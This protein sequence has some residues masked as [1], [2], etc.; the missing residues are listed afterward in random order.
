MNSAGPNIL[1]ITSDQQHWT[2]LGC[3]NPEVP[4]PHL[5]RL[6]AQGR[7]FT[8]AYCPNPT[9]TP[10][11]ASLI[12]GQ[13]PSVHGAW[14]LGTK[15]RETVPTL[16]D[17]FDDLGYDT[18]LIGKAHFQPLASTPDYPSL[19]A[20]PVLQDL[21]FWRGFHGPFY[22]FRHIEIT[23]PHTDE[24]HVGQH[25]AV[26]MEENGL[27]DW[28]RHFQPPTGTTP[29]QYG[30][31]S[32]PPEFHY[33]T[34]ITERSKARLDHCREAGQPFFLWA[35]FFDPHPPYLVPEPWASLVDPAAV[36]VPEITPGEHDRNPPHFHK[37]QEPGADFG[38]MAREPP[39]GHHGHGIH[40]HLRPRERRARDLALY[41]GMMAFTD[42]CIG[43]ILDHLDTLGLAENTLV[44][45]T[46][47]HGHFY[48]QHG[49][50]AKGPF[51]Y[52]DLIKV[53]LIARWPGRVAPGGR[54]TALQSLV[55]LPVTFLAAA[56]RERPFSMTGL[57]QLPEWTGRAAAVRDHAVVENHHQPTAIN[58]RTYVEDRYKLTL[59][60]NQPYGELFDL[61]ADP[62]EVRNLWDEPEAQ[63][64]K[65]ELTRRL[66]DALL[67]QEPLWMPRISGA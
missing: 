23:R 46:S 18:A 29:A 50:T 28:R 40:C 17:H 44:V 33:N 56:G 65:A 64:L 57:D 15:L 21:D 53:P 38:L 61:E 20:Y 14:S 26:W 36:T 48:G 51:H 59:Y 19:E 55:D 7:L 42:H 60:W 41:H 12:T 31:W 32:I 1:F 52:E 63:S 9:C 22:G 11:R 16:G 24:A 45:F 35:S 58:L 34:W 6:A 25:Y 47:D 3:L 66:V 37:T 39:H 2:Q 13:M 5:D 10:T 49:L 54:S 43:Q 67:A 62:G 27:R 30:A 4:T 8:R